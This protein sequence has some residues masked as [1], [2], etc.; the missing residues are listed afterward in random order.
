MK[1]EE[2]S[3]VR[4]E[5]L[6]DCLTDVW[7]QSVRISHTFLNEQDIEN[8]RPYVR[9]ALKEVDHLMMV[10]HDGMYM[11]FMG[12]DDHKI[13][14]LFLAPGCIGRGVGSRL[15]DL[16]V[17]TYGVDKVDV[18]EANE[19]ARKFYDHKGFYVFQRDEIDG[20]GNPFPILHM[21]RDRC[22]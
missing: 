1:I 5:L 18:N 14:M 7:N 19:M 22:E 11:G 12:I 10:S 20:Q 15:V 6:L 17:N 16:A 3:G 8:I 4:D 2:I 13:E 21:T 9:I